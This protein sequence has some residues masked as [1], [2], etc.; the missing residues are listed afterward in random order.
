M[1]GYDRGRGAYYAKFLLRPDSR[2]TFA[3]GWLREVRNHLD[4]A[5]LRRFF[6][7]LRAAGAYLAHQRKLK[8]LVLLTPLAVAAYCAAALAVAARAWLKP[9]PKNATAEL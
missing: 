3:A 8:S 7:E 4:R 6:C 2:L 5:H 1:A 9:K